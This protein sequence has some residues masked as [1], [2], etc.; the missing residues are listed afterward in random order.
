MPVRNLIEL[1]TLIGTVSA[2]K[3]DEDNEQDH[4][5]APDRTIA[6][7]V[8]ADCGEDCTEC[9]KHKHQPVYAHLFAGL[10]ITMPQI[11]CQI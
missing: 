5:A 8:T 3:P 11:F 4:A 9:E 6:E 10:C 1:R 7:Y 2:D